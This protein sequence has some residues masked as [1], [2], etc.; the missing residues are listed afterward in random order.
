M[1][2]TTEN[3]I[4]LNIIFS[5]C[6]VLATIL[7]SKL[8][9]IWNHFVV[10]SAVVVYG[11]TFLC[12]DIIGELWGK[13]EA[14]KTVMNGF[15]MQ[16]MATILIQIAIKLPIA[17]FMEGF[18]THFNAVL[19]GTMRMTLASL[20]AYLVSQSTDVLIFHKIKEINNDNHKWL[21]N[22]MSTIISQLL[23][24]AIFVGIGFYGIV[25]N[26]WVM[27]YSQWF[28]KIIIALCDTPFFYYFTRKNKQIA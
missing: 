14:N 25:P 18:Q 16:I 5:I 1:K 8:I 2:K 23:D 12:T 21:R 9:I 20:V 19:N 11:V 6:L 10:P 15:L 17:P 27:I 22:N 7:A 3:L 28:I 13:E 26:L 4:L 24:T